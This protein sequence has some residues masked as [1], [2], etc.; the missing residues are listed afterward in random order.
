MKKE[1]KGLSR[2]VF[3]EWL[4]PV[5][6]YYFSVQKNEAIFEMLIPLMIAIVSSSVYGAVG[7]ITVA[8]DALA[9]LLPSAISIL[10]GFTVM[11]ITLL[12]TSETPAIN[13]LKAETTENMVHGKYITL[14]Q[15][16]H[17]QLTESLF[18]EIILLLITFAYLFYKGIG[19]SVLFEAVIMKQLRLRER[20]QDYYGIVVAWSA[21]SM[22]CADTVYAGPELE[23]EAIDPLYE[24]W[25]TGLG[26][27]DINIF[28][29]FQSLKD[30]YLD[31]LRLIEDITYADSIGHEIIALND[32]SYIMLE[33]GKTTLYGEA[34]KILD[35][36]QWQICK[37]GESRSL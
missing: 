11:F 25:I 35:G 34:Y 32:G 20:L 30:D 5:L 7:K 21:G 6:D 36:K 2:I 19:S 22:N 18:S 12:L 13:D 24:R 16:L 15:K 27:T 33:D 9:D 4:I 37:D 1:T 3:M 31:G 17:I 23:G 28:P 14:Y 26:L 8:L 29:H 10:I